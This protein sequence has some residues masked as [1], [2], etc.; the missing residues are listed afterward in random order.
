MSTQRRKRDYNGELKE[1]TK[2]ARIK[3]KKAVHISDLNDKYLKQIFDYLR[4]ED[5]AN[6]AAVNNHFNQLVFSRLQKKCKSKVHIF[7]AA[8]VV[9]LCFSGVKGKFV[10][11]TQLD[12]SD[13]FAKLGHMISH[14]SITVMPE[15]TQTQYEEV[16]QVVFRHCGESLTKIEI[17]SSLLP[18]VI[19]SPLPFVEDVNLHR[20]KLNGQLSGKLPCVRRLVLNECEAIDPKCIETHFECLEELTVIGKRKNRNVF[21]KANVQ[22][23][24]RL[25]PQIHRLDINFNSTNDREVGANHPEFELNFDFY[26]FVSEKLSQLQALKMYGERTFEPDE[27]DNDIE[28]YRLEHL[29]IDFILS[30]SPREVAPFTFNRLHKLSLDHLTSLSNEWIHFI[31][32]NAD[33]R[34]LAIGMNYDSV[35]EKL[36]IRKEQL[37]EIIKWLPKLK[38]LRLPAEAVQA[39]DVVAILSKRKSLERIF[40]QNYQE[41]DSMVETFDKLVA[42]RKWLV[43]YSCE[44]IILVKFQS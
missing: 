30:K 19:T 22:E 31:T 14:I 9:W 15:Y 3:T 8:S 43:D 21:K 26:R 34:A 11:K 35:N 7:C 4:L 36:K 23:V 33:L 18:G 39:A 10:L 44:D 40:L 32:R 6:V 27:C 16:E 13:F 37:L 28:F 5:L 12:L 24:I 17:T 29:S 20:C 2:V 1:S 25:N 41:V 38:E 42:K